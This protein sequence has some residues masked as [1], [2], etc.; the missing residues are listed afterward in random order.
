MNSRIPNKTKKQRRPN[1]IKNFKE[2]KEYLNKQ[3]NELQENANK[4]P[5]DCKRSKNIKLNEM[6]KE[7]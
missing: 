1:F 5:S 6:N 3:F 4:C 2:F 7:I